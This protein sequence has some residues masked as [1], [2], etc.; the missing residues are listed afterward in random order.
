[1]IRV[2][3]SGAMGRLG[4]VVAKAISTADNMQ[5]NGVYG[6]GHA[7]KVVAGV[8]VEDSIEDINA[9][10]I[11]ECTHPNVVMENLKKWHAKGVGVVVGTSGFTHERIQEV[12]A[13]AFL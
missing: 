12:K 6:P 11:V 7:G 10:I 5:L 4:S 13:L 2:A 3:V 8:E 9:E 1:M